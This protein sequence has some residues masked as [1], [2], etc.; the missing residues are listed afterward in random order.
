MNKTTKENFAVVTGASQGLG[1]SFAI[2]LAKKGN[3][4]LLLSLPNEGLANLC[5]KLEKQF[6][7]KTVPYETDLSIKEN[8]YSVTDWI[9][10]NYHINVLINNVGIGGTRKFDEVSTS[11]IETMIGLNVMATSI[12]T[13]RLL[14]NLKARDKANILNISSLAG[15]SPIGYK[16][17]YPASK[18]FV[19]SFSRG[20]YQELIDTSVCVSVVAPG[21]MKTNGNATQRIEKQGFCARVTL[22]DTNKVARYCIKQLE[23]RK[24]VI[25][26]N[27][28]SWLVLKLVPTWISLPIITSRFKK[29]LGVGV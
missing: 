2:E 7:I 28:F 15:Y 29:E 3:N 21:P 22:L 13:H 11:Y 16:T 17:V 10:E 14:P 19:H 1:K 20:L 24:A 9:N 12:L 25:H 27:R 6:K 4:L 23:K 5:A 26:V 8:L 18:A